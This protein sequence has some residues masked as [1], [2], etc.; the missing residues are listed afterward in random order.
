MKKRL[1]LSIITF[2]ILIS[3]IIST[4]ALQIKTTNVDTNN[5]DGSYLPIWNIGNYWKYNMDMLFIY[6]NDDGKK[7]LKIDAEITNMYANLTELII[8]NNE[9]IYKLKLDGKITGTVDFLFLEDV[10]QLRGQFGGYAYIAKDTLGI[11]EFEFNVDGEVF[12]G[13]RW[14]ELKYDMNMNFIPSFNFFEFPI[15]SDDEPWDMYIEEANLTASVFIDV[16]GGKYMEFSNSTAFN[17]I[18]SLDRIETIIL[19]NA[20]TFETFVLSGTWGDPSYLWYAPEAGYLIKVDE[21]LDWDN[22]SIISNFYLELSETNYEQ[23]NNP[24]NKPST[25][26]GDDVGQTNQELTYTSLS[27]DPEENQIYYL[28]DWGDNK[29][30]GWLGPFDSGIPCEAVHS[31]TKKGVYN[32]MVKAKDTDNLESEWSDPF[33]VK[34]FGQSHIFLTINHIEGKDELD[35]GSDP[36]WYYSVVLIDEIGQ[37]NEVIE[38]N[39]VNGNWISNNVWGPEI[40]HEFEATSRNMTIQIKLM[41]HDSLSELGTDDLADISGSDIPDCNGQDNS[42]DFKRGAIY[43]GTYNV[44]NSK[45]KDYSPIPD[46]NADMVEEIIPNINF[47]TSGDLSPD[48]STQFEGGIIPHPENDAIVIF[49]IESDYDKPE[50]S[51]KTISLPENIRPTD[52]IEFRGTVIGGNPDYSWYWDFGDGKTSSIQNPSHSYTKDG[53]YTV[54]L[55]LI[56][57]FGEISINSTQII[58]NKNQAPTNLVIQGPEK[59]NINN[60][61]HF[62]FKATDPDEDL[63]YYL[64]DWDDGIDTGWLGPYLSDTIITKSHQWKTKSVYTITFT[65]KDEYG[66]TISKNHRLSMPRIYN[67]KIYIRFLEQFILK[68]QLLKYIF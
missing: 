33:S 57:S 56:D 31:W 59:G 43:H 61:Y 26:T 5:L 9:E 50:V 65:V 44:I 30:S 11:K 1:I 8:I 15:K 23:G 13:I 25:P 4:T 19:P 36:E 6:N 17:D 37:T 60:K 35:V 48:D 53:T 55:T 51:I 2:S 67:N 12:T 58:V 24:P 46:E 38:Y 62:N 66:D 10:A 28:F 41:D 22:G 18:I 3:S 68:Y 7:V 63:L 47:L 14:R 20:G 34:I 49:T 27:I 39:K 52:N 16:L 45:L 54:T 21:T 64:I 29:N 42:V 32:L 40:H